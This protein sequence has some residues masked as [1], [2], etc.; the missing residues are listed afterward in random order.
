[1]PKPK[2]TKKRKDKSSGKAAPELLDLSGHMAMAF[3]TPIAAYE[4]PDSEALNDALETV[5][6]QKE[7][8]SEGMT[9]SNVSGWHSNVDFFG[10]D[11]DCVKQVAKRTEQMLI[12][13]MRAVTVAPEQGDT[14]S[15]KYRLDGW[16]NINRRG[17]YNTVHNHPNCLWSGVYY[18]APGKPDP[19]PAH[20][21]KLEL[22]DPR[23]GTN[24]LF[25]KGT[26][27]QARYVIDPLPGLM[28]MFPAWLNHFAHPFFG[29]GE[30]ISI[31]FNIVTTEI[32]PPEHLA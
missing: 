32:P 10:W 29:D 14:R 9:R 23:A 17:A 30:R 2:K 5:I 7:T 18:V 12:S 31:A 24:M 4:W 1:M 6:L 20:N 13:L 16:A 28:V 8:D 26:I 15:F 21:G 19:E 22:L 3:G 11:A 27:F 25:T